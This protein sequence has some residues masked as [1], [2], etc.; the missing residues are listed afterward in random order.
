MEKDKPRCSASGGF[1]SD[2]TQSSC[3]LLYIQLSSKTTRLH[4]ATTATPERFF[5]HLP[6]ILSYNIHCEL[7][8]S[9]L[10]ASPALPWKSWASLDKTSVRHEV[11]RLK[12]DFVINLLVCQMVH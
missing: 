10:M 11:G 9:L 3:C 12:T 7:I 2:H 6:A 5:Y 8:L 4:K 1:Y